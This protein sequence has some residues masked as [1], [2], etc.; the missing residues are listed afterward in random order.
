MIFFNEIL[1]KINDEKYFSDEVDRLEV[2]LYGKSESDKS[3][4]IENVTD[5]LLN[6]YYLERSKSKTKGKPND[7]KPMLAYQCAAL[8]V[9]YHICRRLSYQYSKDFVNGWAKRTEGNYFPFGE[10]MRE[11]EPQQI[12][13]QAELQT[14]EAKNIFAKAIKAGLMENTETGCYQWNKSKTLLAYFAQAMS[15]YLHLSNKQ[16]NGKYDTSWKP[17]EI[18]FNQNR[19]KDA[20]QSWLKDNYKESEEFYPDG[21]EEISQLFEK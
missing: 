11:P 10:M 8:S 12:E 2:F 7:I 14:D 19:L 6:G 13:I 21:F 15:G 16:H 17:F 18:A 5:D 4:I 3:H 9:I 20:K 1:E